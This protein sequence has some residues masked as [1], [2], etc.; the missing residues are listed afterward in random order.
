MIH[1]NE[2]FISAE[3]LMWPCCF[4]SDWQV[5]GKEQINEKLA[6][7]G[8]GWNSLKNKSINEILAHPWFDKILGESWNPE[9]PKHLPR[10]IR[11]CAYNKAYHNEL[12]DDKKVTA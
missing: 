4:L 8:D 1:E 9:H 5:K 11:T 2:I 12:H 7:Y 3:Q 6:E 10:C